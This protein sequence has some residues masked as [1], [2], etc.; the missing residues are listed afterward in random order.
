MRAISITLRARNTATLPLSYNAFVQGLLYSCWSKAFPELH[1]EGFANPKPFRLFTF[2]P[3]RG[4]CA[5][6][7]GDK[8]ITFKDLIHF[9]VRS[10]IEELLDELAIQLSS[11][12]AIRLGSEEMEL[13]NLQSCD[14]LIFPQRAVLKMK[15]PVVAYKTLESGYTQYYAPDD[16]EWLDLIK[17]NTANKATI[18]APDCDSD[19]IVIP[20]SETLRKHVTQFKGTNITGWTGDLIVA[21]DPRILSMLYYSGIGIKNSQ[22]FGLFNILDEKL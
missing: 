18:L 4:P 19:L 5:I 13:V 20:R 16:Q 14:R 12:N 11:R 7:K 3:L 22:G 15:A 10:P 21:A 1:D 2:S 9:E 6:S 17:A 8:T